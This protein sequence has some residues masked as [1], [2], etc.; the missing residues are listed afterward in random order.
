MVVPVEWCITAGSQQVN[1]CT[2]PTHCA[3][4]TKNFKYNST[5]NVWYIDH[6]IISL[7]TPLKYEKLKM[8]T[9]PFANI[10]YYGSKSSVYGQRYE[11]CK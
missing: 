6:L 11:R 7:I 9:L 3:N 5:L 10:K 2:K 8:P 1:V 4:I